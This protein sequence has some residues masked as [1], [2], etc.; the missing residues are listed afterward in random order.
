MKKETD[1]NKKIELPELN[2]REDKSLMQQDYFPE[3]KT[4]SK[5]IKKL[6]DKLTA[7]EFKENTNN[8]ALLKENNVI[9]VNS[10]GYFFWKLFAVMCFLLLISFGYMVFYTDSLDSFISPNF[11]NT[12][13]IEN[14]FTVDNQIEVPV[15]I[16]DK[17]TNNY[18]N[19]FTIY[20]NVM[21]P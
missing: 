6:K 10:K 17:D 8:N 18:E 3:P 12:I 15:S 21:C 2:R 5:R 14:N 9:A 13:N 4:E 16:D 20:N 11:N 1:F 19:N 7:E